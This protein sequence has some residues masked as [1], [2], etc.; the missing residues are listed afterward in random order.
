M[1][2]P[3]MAR[4]QDA[5]W[6]TNPGNG[7]FNTPGNWTPATVPT[8][9]ASFGTSTVTTL[10]FSA[11]STVGGWTFNTGASHYTFTNAQT[12]QFNG[13][14]I[15]VNGGS[16]TITNNFNILFNNNSSAGNAAI[17]NNDG[18]SFNN[19]ST[20]GTAAIANAGTGV[21]FSSTTARPATPSSPTA[22]SGRSS[23][24]AP[25]APETPASPTIATRR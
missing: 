1:L 18:L 8:G 16:A 2:P 14:G 23:S 19:G 20:A 22:S 6:S 4:A 5:T 11:D 3:G 25:P 13:A 12:L 15:V 21:V 9:T 17:T 7:D 10:S 24:T